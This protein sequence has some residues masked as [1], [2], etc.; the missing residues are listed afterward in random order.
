MRRAD[1]IIVLVR[2]RIVEEGTHDELFARG[3]EYR[4]LYDLQFMATPEADVATAV[5]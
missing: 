4:K 3:Q 5:N 1:K 2:G